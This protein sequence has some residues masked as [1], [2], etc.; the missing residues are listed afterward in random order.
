MFDIL[1]QEI[2]AKLI[3]RI[4]TSWNIMLQ[5]SLI[6]VLIVHDSI[7]MFPDQLEK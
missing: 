7:K 6:H 5:T 4:S 1:S 3:V 2:D